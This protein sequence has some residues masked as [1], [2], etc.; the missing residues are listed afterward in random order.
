MNL[1]AVL[2][3]A[4]EPL[5]Q[6]WSWR[7]AALY[8]LALGIGSDPLDADEL[9]YVYEGRKPADPA[10]RVRTVPSFCVTLG[11]LPF[12]Q[13]DPRFG[14]AWQRIVHGELAFTLHAPLLAE[15]SVRAMHRLVSVRDKG[16]A[17][18]AVV[19]V[20]KE[21]HDARTG[22]LLASVRSVEFL[23]DDGGCGS[24]GETRES[25]APLPADF[26]P[27]LQVDYATSRQAALLYRLASGDPM[28]IHAD[29][30]IARGAGFERPISHGV[31]NLGLACRAVLK[32]VLPGRPQALRGMAVRF[33]QPGYPGDTVRVELQRRGDVV[34]FRARALERDAWLL[35]RGTAQLGD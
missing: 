14:I 12:W 9:P 25:L 21:L 18:G 22:A 13:D 3:H 6:A 30:A 16:A 33:V 8:A 2:D 26:D 20:D 10:H 34:H 7:D 17:R 23:R 4:F 11:W 29:P 31:H 35:D 19:H 28:P 15:G 1:S 27:T 24:W 5:T 32:H